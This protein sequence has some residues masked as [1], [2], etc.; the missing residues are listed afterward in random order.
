[1]TQTQTQTPA[2]LKQDASNSNPFAL[3]RHADINQGTVAIEESRAI[4][5]AQGKLV[6][7]KKFP[8]DQAAAFERIMK[9]CSRK[10]LAESAMYSFPRGGQV[11]TGPS[12]RLAEELA[13]AWGNIEY[14]IRELSQ[15]DGISEMESYCWDLETNVVSSQ[16][17]TVKH[18]RHTKTGVQKLTDPRDIYE[19]TANNAG[20]RLRARILAVLPPDIVDAA[21]EECYR[22]LA[23]NSTEPLEDRV[24]K[25]LKAFA[26]YGINK[27]HI[28]QRL[29]K[30][31]DA[32]LSEELVELQT[33]YTSLKD[34]ISRA[35]D[36]FGGSLAPSGGDSAISEINDKV[37]KKPR[38]AAKPAANPAEQ[39]TPPLQ[40]EPPVNEPPA[41]TVEAPQ[42]DII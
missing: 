5:E 6:V 36:W 23:G 18:E 4:A 19:L 33:I 1:M 28:E 12:I 31:L 39:Q 21:V 9:S 25:M 3:T 24:R 16:K 40:P 15:K 8:R 7:A 14:G 22:T 30:K 26:P 37:A 17:F 29:G 35:S 13:R 27:E 41:Q 42:D 32:L 34:G 2:V 20:R 11:I 38:A 10:K